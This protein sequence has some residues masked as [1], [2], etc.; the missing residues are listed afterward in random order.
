MIT[1]TTGLVLKNT[2]IAR[3]RRMLVLFTRKFGKI[4]A[5]TGLTPRGKN[6]SQLALGPFTY[7]RYQLFKGREFNVDAAESVESFFEIGE[8]VDKYFAASC[9]LEYVDA[10]LPYEQPAEETLDTLLSFFRILKKRSSRYRSLLLIFQWIVL[11]QSGFM[12]DLYTCGHCGRPMEAAALSVADGSILCGDCLETCLREGKVNNALLYRD[13][14]DIIAI[15]KFIAGNGLE[16][17][18]GLS[19]NPDAEAYLGSILKDVLS[20]HLNINKLKSET[21]LND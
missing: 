16:C 8:N 7:G 4:S 9:A 18:A 2:K 6:R 21:Y 15:L 20:Y 11:A 19:L 17:F 1:E 12:P 3:D 13:K 10:I 5:G 14:F